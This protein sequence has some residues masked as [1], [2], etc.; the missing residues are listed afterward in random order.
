MG[1]VREKATRKLIRNL[2]IFIGLIIITFGLIFKDQD[3]NKLYSIIMSVD[4]RFLLLGIALMM[5]TY[6]IESYNVR[7]ILIALGDKKISMLNAIKYTM[8]GFFFSAITPAATGGQ[9]VE[10]Y[11]MTKDRIQ[12]GN[13]TMAL[14]LQL[15]GFQISTISLGIICAIINP[16]ILADGLIWFF[17]LGITINGFALFMMLVC[18]FSERLTEKLVNIFMKILLFFKVKNVRPKIKTL[19][20]GL[21]KYKESSVFI[22]SHKGEFIKAILRVFIQ[23]LIYYTIPYCVYKAFGLSDYTLLQVLPMQAVLYTIV[24]GLPLPG[25]IGVSETAFL[26][27]FGTV[28]G[29]ELLSSAVLLSRG[30]TFYLF[31]VVS[32]IIVVINAIKKKN[33]KGEIDEQALAYEREVENESINENVA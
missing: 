7:A 28:F 4:K 29:I 23:I 32:L 31:V 19:R 3:M 5:I 8:I 14:L 20:E 13:A 12:G 9:P 6:L 27:I 22:K 18:I 15:C 33:I 10:V 17:L 1:I 26:K 11:Y 24:S 30:V 16:Q 25:A 2:L 21:G